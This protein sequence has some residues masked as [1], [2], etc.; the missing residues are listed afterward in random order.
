MMKKTGAIAGVILLLAGVV[1]GQGANFSILA[2]GP[3]PI[4]GDDILLPGPGAYLNLMGVGL[5]INALSIAHDP[6]APPA[7]FEFSIDRVSMGFPGTAASVEAA[8]MD[9]ACDIYSTPADGSN[10]LLWD[11]DGVL[12]LPNPPTPMLGLVEQGPMEGIM[13]DLDAWENDIIGPGTLIFFSLDMATAFG[14][15][16]SA[17]D[18]LMAPAIPGYDAPIPPPATYAT[19]LELGLD[20]IMDD[21]DALVV[22]DDGDYVFGPGDYILFSLA[23]SSPSFLPGDILQ[24]SFGS[25]IIP[26]IPAGS[27][28]L[29]PSDNVDALDVILG[30]VD[31]GGY[32]GW[33]QQYSLVGGDAALDADVDEFGIGDGMDNLL[34]Y[35][36]GGDPTV[37]DAATIQ[38]TGS[39]TQEGGIN[40]FVHVHNER[41]DDGDLTFTVQLNTNLVSGTW[42]ST[43]VE[44]VDESGVDGN[45][46]KSVTNRISADAETQ[47]FLRLEVG[48]ATGEEEPPPQ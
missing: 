38:P 28:G 18:V 47:Q 32:I 45:G 16:M 46:F 11:G 4:F 23:P 8:A 40:W 37:S 15:G 27:L 29:A 25:P 48:M 5:D 43:G 36:L 30:T 31:P 24:A 1:F 9:Q 21:I 39:I 10:T 3:T 14:V 35:A 19:A 26:L 7:S 17:A 34:E 2:N 13:D 12:T 41:T 33:A 6:L 22:F 20:P 42:T 44:F